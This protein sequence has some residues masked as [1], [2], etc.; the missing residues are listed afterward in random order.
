MPRDLA[1]RTLRVTGDRTSAGWS[2]GLHAHVAWRSVA[3]QEAIRI[4]S[5]TTPQC[6]HFF[7]ARRLLILLVLCPTCVQIQ[8]R[9]AQFVVSSLVFTA[10]LANVAVALLFG[11]ARLAR[12]KETV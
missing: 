11:A 12:E 7:P 6:H 4:A 10:L 3:R 2:A 5:L 9:T 1:S 8:L